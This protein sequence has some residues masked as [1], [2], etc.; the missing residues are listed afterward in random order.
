MLKNLVPS[1]KPGSRVVINDHCLRD[2]G[3]ERPWDEKLI[4]SMDLIMLTLL[5]AQERHEH[6]FRALFRAAD[7]RFAFKVRL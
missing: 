7:E 3:M 2:P 4:R 5:N 1:L 6:E